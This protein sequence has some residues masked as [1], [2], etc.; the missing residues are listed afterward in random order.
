MFTRLCGLH[1]RVHIGWVGVRFG[2]V[3]DRSAGEQPNGNAGQLGGVCLPELAGGLQ[4]ASHVDGAAEHDRLVALDG[5]DLPRAPDIHRCVDAALPQ[6]LVEG[7]AEALSDL[8]GR[9]VPAR[10][11]YQN[12]HDVPPWLTG[13]PRAAR[14][15]P[16][17][18][19]SSS[20]APATSRPVAI[21]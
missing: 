7:L 13:A 17:A 2:W 6:L 21:V 1:D 9:A 16:A 11:G 4:P 18:L 5:R 3:A 15:M 14:K 8:A 20:T 12:L 10:D 19:R